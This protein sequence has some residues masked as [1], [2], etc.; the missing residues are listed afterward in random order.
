MCVVRDNQGCFEFDVQPSRLFVSVDYIKCRYVILPAAHII[1]K[2]TT[3]IGL[4]GNC[5]SNMYHI[6]NAAA[7][8]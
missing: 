5:Q 8:A 3:H 6:I 4:V 2:E 7:A 1:E